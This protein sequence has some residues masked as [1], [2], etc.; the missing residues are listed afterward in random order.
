A[1]AAL[2][3]GPYVIVNEGTPHPITIGTACL[4][5]GVRVLQYR[6]KR[7]ID[8][9]HLHELRDRTAREGALLIV[10]DDIEVALTFD[11]DGVHLGPDDGAFDALDPVRACMAERLIGISAGTPDEARAAQR[12][13]ADYVGIGAVFATGSKDDA[14]APIGVAG[15]RD[16]AAACSLP[17]AAI[18]G[19]DAGNI[20]EVARTNVAMAAVI[21]AVSS[22]ADPEAAARELVAIWN[23]E[24]GA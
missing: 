24:R 6:A 21:S 2:L 15:L 9:T 1:R 19:I 18:G 5:A 13:G 4:R 7:G 22:A 14:G 12:A 10:N 23:R 17:A 8:H 16:I 3:R 20:A 11:C